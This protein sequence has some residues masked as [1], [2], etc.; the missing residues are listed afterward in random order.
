MGYQLLFSMLVIISALASFINSKY[1]KLPKSIGLTLTTLLIS[2][3][4][5]ILL[6]IFP[7]WFL[8]VKDLLSGVDFKDIVCTDK[9]R[10][11]AKAK[12]NET[13][14]LQLGETAPDFTVASKNKRQY[15][16]QSKYSKLYIE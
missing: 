5:L 9:P 14:T 1:L 16:K 12:E 4:V 2:L 3:V 6:K 13:M 10:T 8:P 7:D 11:T 15:L